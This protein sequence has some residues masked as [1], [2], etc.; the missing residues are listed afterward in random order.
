[1][2]E[3]LKTLLS[4]LKFKNKYKTCSIQH[5]D[6]SEFAQLPYA[7]S[8]LLLMYMNHISSSCNEEVLCIHTDWKRLRFNSRQH[9]SKARK[10]LIDGQWIYLL[11]DKSIIVNPAKIDYL[12]IRQRRYFYSL[13]DLVDTPNIL[14]FGTV[15]EK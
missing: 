1:M 8:R 6:L 2:N 12:T 14:P 7:S 4:K 5:H 15:K 11:E 9:Y 3:L 10:L 13:Y